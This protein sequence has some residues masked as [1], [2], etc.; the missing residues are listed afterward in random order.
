LSAGLYIDTTKTDRFYQESTGITLAASVTDPMGIALDQRLWG[1]RT[2]DAYL[3]TLANLISQPVA[4]ENVYWSVGGGASITATA[5]T[6]PDGSSTARTLNFGGGT[7]SALF[8]NALGTA[9]TIHANRVWL[10]STTVSGTIKF[11]LGDGSSLPQKTLT[12]SWQQ[13]KISPLM[14]GN[15]GVQIRRDNAGQLN[16]VE[17]WTEEFK[18]VPGNAG[19]QASGTLKPLL[20]TTGAKFDGSDDNW[21]T[22]FLAQNGANFIVARA[23]VPASISAAQVIAGA[24]GAAANRCFLAIDTSGRV[25]G[26][27]GSDSTTTIVGTSD[28]RGTDVVVGI[29]LDGTTVKLFANTAEEYSAVQN[30][31]PTVA[32]PFRIGANN[33]NGTAGSFFGGSV[34]R[35]V[36]GY[37]SL[38]LDKFKQIRNALLAA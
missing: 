26:G 30:S 23:L 38:T 24:S 35:I 11:G 37:D 25:C 18:L 7:A 28:L 31:T 13:F 32:V 20:Q 22:P 29:S 17:V 10:R 4:L 14:A 27:V 21:L 1:G 8:R 36:G 16:E 19:T 34:K 3:D 6:A 15:P 12:T 33:N 5:G 2:Y 9:G